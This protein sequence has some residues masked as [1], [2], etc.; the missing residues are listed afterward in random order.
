MVAT[1]KATCS[2]YFVKHLITLP[3]SWDKAV[4][5]NLVSFF[6]HCYVKFAA[7]IIQQYVEGLFLSSDVG[8]VTAICLCRAEYW[9]LQKN[10]IDPEQLAQGELCW[11]SV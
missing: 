6:R 10:V 11:V 3:L 7:T 9:L 8:V 1:T 2:Y 4:W 5:S